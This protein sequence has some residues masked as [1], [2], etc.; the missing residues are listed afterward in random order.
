ME[1]RAFQSI[2]AQLKPQLDLRSANV[3]SGGAAVRS[4]APKLK[5]ALHPREHLVTILQMN[6]ILQTSCEHLPNTS[7]SEKSCTYLA[8]VWLLPVGDEA[9]SPPGRLPGFGC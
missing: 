4:R 3:N 1:P 8:L 9:R 5:R 2:G 6:T 7:I